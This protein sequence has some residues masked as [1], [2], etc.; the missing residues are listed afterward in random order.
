MS[1]QAHR[2]GQHTIAEWLALPEEGRFELIDGELIQ[3]A[4]P[5]VSHG[6]AQARTSASVS[7]SFDRRR[8]GPG[9]PGGW[10]IASEVD[11]VLDGRGY[12]P[13]LAG[14]RRD[15]VP[16]LP[17]QRPVDVRPDW[18]CE[19]L[20]DSNRNVDTIKKVRRYHQAGVPHYWLLDTENRSLIVYRNSP[21]GY[22]VA[23][24]AEAGEKVRAEPF[25]AVELGVSQL[26]GDDPED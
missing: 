25:D 11:L 16:E 14:W 7:L 3:K 10:W 12:R 19:I 8:G 9:G 18:I 4:A 21:E 1:N 15:R 22:V 5:T 20:S 17:T 2:S 26:L 23:L 6:R 24:T 13:D